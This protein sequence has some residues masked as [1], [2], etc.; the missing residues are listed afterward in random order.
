MSVFMICDFENGE[1]A[2]GFL[3]CKFMSLFRPVKNRSGR[4]LDRIIEG[5]LVR[6]WFTTSPGRGM[7][8][9]AHLV[10]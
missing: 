7:P 1:M 2:L 3:T 10:N 8:S 9:Y 4:S 5:Q 6:F